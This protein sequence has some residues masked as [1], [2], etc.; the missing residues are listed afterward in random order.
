MDGI[1]PW[2]NHLAYHP[3]DIGRWNKIQLDLDI[4]CF[5]NI[6]CIVN[7]P[8]TVPRSG[9]IG[10]YDLPQACSNGKNIRVGG[11]HEYFILWKQGLLVEQGFPVVNPVGVAAACLVGILYPASSVHLVKFCGGHNAVIRQNIICSR[12]SV[13]SEL[14]G[15]GE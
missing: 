14:P 8:V 7:R 13:G 3:G 12:K 2:T 11:V 10:R 4:S 9:G 1:G 15:F 6:Y 5:V